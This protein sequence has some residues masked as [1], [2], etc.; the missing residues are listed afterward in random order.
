MHGEYKTP[1]GKLVVVDC[2]VRDG[3]VVDVQVSGDFF[4]EPAEALTAITAAIEGMPADLD[5]EAIAARVRAALAPD[6]AMI[7]FSPEAVARAVRRALA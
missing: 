6:V 4:L 7:G 1:G 2:E 5:E 3:H